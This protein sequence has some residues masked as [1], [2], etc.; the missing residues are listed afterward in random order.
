MTIINI[1]E[2]FYKTLHKETDNVKERNSKRNKIPKIYNYGY[3]DKVMITINEIEKALNEM[4][5]HKAPR[6]DG[7]TLNTVKH[8]G[9][10]YF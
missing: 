9:L 3:K 4:K 7:A 10:P 8:G 2:T 5:N 6:Y 1:V